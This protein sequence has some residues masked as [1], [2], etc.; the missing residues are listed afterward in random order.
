MRRAA[1]VAL[2]GLAACLPASA[3]LTEVE[4][5]IVERVKSRSA[6]AI[7]LL[8]RSVRVNSGTFNIEG[9]REVG[10]IFAAEL[11]PLGF[12]ARW[13]EMPPEMNRAGHLIAT[14]EGSQ[15]KRVLLVGHLDTVFEKQSPVQLWE[16]SGNKVR[17]QGVVDMKGGDV[18]IIEALRALHELGLLAETTIS[19]VFTGD[20]ERLGSPQSVSR[21]DLIDAAKRSDVALVF[22]G[23]RRL[24]SGGDQAHVARR[25]SSSFFLEVTARPAHSS[26]MFSPGIGLGAIYEGARIL[27]AFRGEVAE[28]GLSFSPGVALGGT[29]VSFDDALASGTA[30]GKSNVIPRLFMVRSD[31]RFLDIV[32]RDRAR[33]K[34]REIV[35]Q[36]LPGTS[37]EI[38]FS[39]GYPPMPA[40]E[41]NRALLAAYSSVSQ[42]AGYGPV[43]AADASQGGA[44]DVQFVAPYVDAIDGVGPWGSGSH[45]VD[46][47]LDIPSIERSAVRAALLIYRLTRGDRIK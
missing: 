9:V 17:G 41:G 34:M 33:A 7:E 36:S 22:E 43:G 23:S 31:M 10:R 42:D 40:T 24:R 21:R 38:R 12:K 32:Q 14:R 4:A 28:P 30:F 2:L 18:A 26:G 8:E 37:A 25:G 47:Q 5:L 6:Q 16:R 46:E 35:A 44:S 45:T 39:D 20:E 11:E 27:N 13:A 1:I 29:V 15:G 3:A 19:V